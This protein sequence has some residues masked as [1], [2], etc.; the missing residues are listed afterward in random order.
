MNPFLCLYS[1]QQDRVEIK[2]DKG[3]GEMAKF[4]ERLSKN[5]TARKCSPLYAMY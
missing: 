5:L 1:E 2:N 4:I 3:H